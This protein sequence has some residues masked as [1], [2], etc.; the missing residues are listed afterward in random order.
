MPHCIARRQ[1]LRFPVSS[2]RLFFDW[3]GNGASRNSYLHCH[4]TQSLQ[5]THEGQCRIVLKKNDF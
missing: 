1:A 3:Q 5:P 4:K 2:P